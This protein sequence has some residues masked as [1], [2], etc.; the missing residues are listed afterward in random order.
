MA[1]RPENLPARSKL[2]QKLNNTNANILTT[3]NMNFIFRVNLARQINF[4]SK[5]RIS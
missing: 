5:I 4:F 3:K 1:F 2:K